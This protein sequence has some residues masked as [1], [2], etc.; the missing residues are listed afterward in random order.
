VD[1]NEAA[2]SLICD[3]T[4]LLH[5]NHVRDGRSGSWFVEST[6]RQRLILQR[7]CGRWLAARGYPALPEGMTQDETAVPGVSIAGRIGIEIQILR[8]WLSYRL[9]AA[10]RR[11]PRLAATA[12]RV[13]RIADPPQVGAVVWSEQ[14]SVQSRR[15]DLV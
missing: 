5:W 3:S 4:T 10:S 11:F 6:P 13:L 9:R 1:L 15:D 2:N 14:R 8:G 12:K 7:V